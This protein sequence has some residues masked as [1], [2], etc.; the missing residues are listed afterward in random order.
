LQVLS[1]RGGFSCLY[2]YL[3]KDPKMRPRL[4]RRPS[5]GI[6]T[7]KSRPLAPK[8]RELLNLI[9]QVFAE[10]TVFSPARLKSKLTKELKKSAIKGRVYATDYFPG[11]G[12]AGLN[13]C[14]PPARKKKPPP[15][16]V[17]DSTPAATAADNG[18]TT[19]ASGTTP[20]AP[21][22]SP[23]VEGDPATDGGADGAPSGEVD[24][25]A[26]ASEA[27]GRGAGV[28]G[29]DGSEGVTHDV[30][31]GTAMRLALPPVDSAADGTPAVVAEKEA[32]RNNSAV[33]Q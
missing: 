26:G 22:P 14:N 27:A 5:F 17:A 23:A 6:S 2:E 33:G 4:P 25:A 30:F 20:A 21:L 10:V 7:P 19:A 1:A 29:G 3:K 12:T 16:P 13:Y 32:P 11:Q 24:A 15:P 9:F 28:D 18:P 31:D 8:L